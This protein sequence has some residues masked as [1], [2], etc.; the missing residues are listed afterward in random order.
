MCLF[1]A[2]L[3][4]CAVSPFLLSFKIHPQLKAQS[5]A[6]NKWLLN[7]ETLTMRCKDDS[8]DDP[9]QRKVIWGE[10]FRCIH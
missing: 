8:K 5:T 6:L 4:M 7:R 9:L 10:G 1:Q 3:G 2:K